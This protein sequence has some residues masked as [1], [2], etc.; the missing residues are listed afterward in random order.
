MTQQTSVTLKTWF[1]KKEANLWCEQLATFLTL[2]FAE[3]TKQPALIYILGRGFY[4][5]HKDILD[6]SA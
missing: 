6:D 2:T 3:H 4:K 5:N 1:R